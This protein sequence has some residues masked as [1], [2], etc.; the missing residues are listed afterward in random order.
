MK[1]YTQPM[2]TDIPRIGPAANDGSGLDDDDLGFVITYDREDGEDPNE[3]EGTIPPALAAAAAI[4]RNRLHAGA[5]ATRWMQ[6]AEAVAGLRL[7]SQ[8]VA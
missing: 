2:S 8:A 3:A 5:V 7:R 4:T 1:G 6:H